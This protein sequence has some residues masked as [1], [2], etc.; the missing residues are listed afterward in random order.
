MMTTAFRHLSGPLRLPEDLRGG[1]VAIG[2]FDGVHLGHQALL[3]HATDWAR[4]H[5]RPTLLLTFDPHPR[6]FF[7]PDEPMFPLT[8]SALKARRVAAS[9]IEAMVSWPFDGALA[10]LSAAAFCELLLTEALG[11]AHVVTGEDFR[12]GNKRGG[13]VAALAQ[14]GVT[15]GFSTS[16]VAPVM[17][18]G[19]PVSST[20]IR[21]LIAAGDI[22]G[23]NALLGWEWSLMATVQHG[24]KRGRALGY[25]TANLHLA[26]TVRLAHGIYAVRATVDG[27]SHAAVASHGRRPT[28]DGGAPK[29]E[30]HVFDFA[31][32]LYGREMEVTFVGYIRPELRFEGIEPLIRQMDQDSAQARRLLGQAAVSTLRA[33]SN[34]ASAASS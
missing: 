23:A 17:G 24:D 6:A 28:F 21:E 14:Q 30:V 10:A 3:R 29:L 31:G 9:G 1:A 26:P 32:D 2:N 20:R 12:F 13:D 7:R 18:D 11:A 27:V 16:A 4:G 22:A 19:A 25:P 33:S 15:L 34:S 8:N 5:R